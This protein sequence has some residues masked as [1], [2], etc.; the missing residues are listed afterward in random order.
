MFCPKCKIKIRCTDSRPSPNNT[1]KRNYKCHKCNNMLKTI[2]IDVNLHDID[3]QIEVNNKI[4]KI[5]NKIL[6]LFKNDFK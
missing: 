3:I 4:S 1:T 5:K 6:E 2:E